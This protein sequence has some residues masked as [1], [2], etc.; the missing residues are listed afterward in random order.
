MLECGVDNLINKGYNLVVTC[1]NCGRHTRHVLRE[2]SSV[3]NGEEIIITSLL[4]TRCQFDNVITVDNCETLSLKKEVIILRDEIK[5]SH[6]ACYREHIINQLVS[7]KDQL[8]NAS[9]ELLK[10]YIERNEV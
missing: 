7:K 5:K 4:C 10:I 8:K 1:D 6:K 2:R 9:E 3:M